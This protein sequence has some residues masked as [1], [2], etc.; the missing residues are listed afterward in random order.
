MTQHPHQHVRPLR[1]ATIA[2]ALAGLLGLAGCSGS[3]EVA[4]SPPVESAAPEG[5]L[6]ED[7]QARLQRALDDT[8][9]EYDVPGAVAGVW[10]PGEGSW[11]TEN[12]TA[13]IETGEPVSL[14]MQWPLRSLTKS[15]TV[16]LLLQLVDEGKMGLGDTIDQ[17]VEGVTDGEKITLRQ[18]AEMSS[19]NADYTNDEFVAV[20]AE[21]QDR[22][23]TLDELL[24]FMLGKPALF[25]PGTEKGY[26]NANTNLIGA[27]IEK[28]TGQPFADVLEER[29]L[30]PV[31]LHDTKY[32]VDAADWT[33]SHPIGYSPDGSEMV[34][35]LTNLSIFGPAGSMTSSLEDARVWAEVLA[36]GELLAPETQAE[37]LKGAPLEFGPP[38][39]SYAMGIG[40]TDGWWGHN[41]EGL[42]FTAALFHEPESGATIAVF[43]NES[44]LPDHSHPADQAF[45]RLAEVVRSLS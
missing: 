38:Y 7:L 17:Y 20:L 3:P 16:T 19:G 41:G 13:N 23:F 35:Q 24:S 32:N 34:D 8:M 44:N 22:I 26:V 11:A 2:V 36:T 30:L 29:I 14:E 39:D 18:L 10:I 15:F 43:M 12:G 25:Q 9:A 31:G 5:E 1:Y 28:A 33:A 37:R 40:E 6:S 42:G 27:A 21:D 4:T 45:R